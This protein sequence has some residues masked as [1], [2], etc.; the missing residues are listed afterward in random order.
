[1]PD[2]LDEE[3]S[4]LD[5][6]EV[7][8]VVRPH[9]TLRAW[10]AAWPKLLAMALVVALWQV[11]AWWSA[12]R[13]PA[14][15]S[16]G[17]VSA[18]LRADLLTTELWGAVGATLAR[19]LI[20]FTLAACIGCS[21]GLAVSRWSVLRVALGSMITGLQTMPSIA[22]FPLA[23]LFFEGSQAA[24]M[25]VV[26]L[27][28]APSIANGIISGV[29]TVPPLLRR[30]GTS[31]GAGTVTLYRDIVVPAAMPSVLGGLKQ[32]WAF[33]WRSLLAGELLVALPVTASLGQR[34][35]SF[36]IAEDAVGLL[37]TLLVVLAIGILVDALVF[38]RAERRVLT[39]RGLT[40][41]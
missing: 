29:D 33:S 4:G 6:L 2:I 11:V 25:F 18:R 15:P 41:G 5:H 24:I 22:W 12:S 8:T 27:G 1:M 40:S 32:G 21:I 30:L 13:N 17:D 38:G 10:A 31:M 20:G 36:R 9:W 34:L 3:L 39:R 16:P 19:A 23:L 26:V 28:A 37:A 35:Q 7:S 14:V